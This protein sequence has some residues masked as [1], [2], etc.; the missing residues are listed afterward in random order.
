MKSNFRRR[1]PGS[2]CKCCKSIVNN[3]EKQIISLIYK[4]IGSFSTEEMTLF[5]K[6]RYKLIAVLWE[7]C[8]KFL[9]CRKVIAFLHPNSPGQWFIQFYPPPNRGRIKRDTFQAGIRSL[10]SFWSILIPFA[11]LSS[12]TNNDRIIT[13]YILYFPKSIE[14]CRENEQ[15]MT[16]SSLYQ[17]TSSDSLTDQSTERR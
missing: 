17:T 14:S 4:E 6:S 16:M 7:Q 1:C 3:R 11:Y 9:G 13:I 8:R 10:F 12:L 15:K 2:V 5:P